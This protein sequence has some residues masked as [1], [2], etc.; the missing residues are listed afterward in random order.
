MDGICSCD[1][2]TDP[3]L[4]CCLMHSLI[5]P[6]ISFGERNA[7]SQIPVPSLNV[8]SG[9]VKLDKSFMLQGSSSPIFINE[10][11]YVSLQGLG[12]LRIAHEQ[13]LSHS[14]PSTHPPALLLH[15]H[16]LS[17]VLPTHI[18]HNYLPDLAGGS[19]SYH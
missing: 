17:L 2:R 7:S 19:D 12:L 15:I 6:N 1:M 16:P 4:K 11:S 8:C 3:G 9:S 13:R 5:I 18:H 14:R 10:H